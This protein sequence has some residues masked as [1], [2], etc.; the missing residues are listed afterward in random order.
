MAGS[1]SCS[2]A[3][4]WGSRTASISAMSA[5]TGARTS[6]TPPA[7][8]RWSSR[9][10][11]TSRI[12]STRGST[13]MCSRAI[14]TTSSACAADIGTP[15]ARC[16]IPARRAQ[17]IAT[18]SMASW[19]R[20]PAV[21]GRW[22][23]AAATIA[24][25][26]S[27]IPSHAAWPA[28]DRARWDSSR[29]SARASIRSTVSTTSAASEDAVAPRAA[30]AT[31]TSAAASPGASLIPS[32]TMIVGPRRPAS[33]TTWTLS[34]GD[35]SQCTSSTPTSR[36]TDW[37][38]SARSPVTRT[39]C[40]M[41]TER[42]V[43]SMRGASGRNRSVNSR[44]ATG[45]P[46]TETKAVSEPSS[47][48][49]RR[50]RRAQSGTCSP[51]TQPA[52]PTRTAAPSACAWIP[53]PDVSRASSGTRRSRPRMRAWATTAVASTCGDIWSTLAAS[54]R[55]SSLDHSGA[56]VIA[57]S[58]GRPP[59]RVPVLSSSSTRPA[60]RRSSAAPPLT[61]TPRR[62]HCETPDITA[63][64]TASSRGQGVATTRTA[65]A[66]LGCPARS[67]A[68]AATTR[69]RGTNQKARRSASRTNGAEPRRAS[70]TSRTTPA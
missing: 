7:A 54:S 18:T 15:A 36:P 40:S 26:L 63:I 16:G 61:T 70:S 22:P 30:S 49:R 13:A 60:A 2:S 51:S 38:R 21:T 43:R 1:S 20:A 10:S 39:T 67:H 50:V 25:M 4:S 48:A 59:V 3:R 9:P 37:A 58:T 31:P 34:A 17:R 12:R 62:A 27:P 35:C 28:I 55:A 42:R 33:R 47:S 41:P 24:A 69:A 23:S 19:S 56:V 6:A 11:A 5:A 53:S 32:P 8:S 66:A 68:A 29:A 64:G 52:R 57:S 44:P 45:W 14:R 46:P 65:T